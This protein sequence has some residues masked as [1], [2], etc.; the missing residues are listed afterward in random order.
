MILRGLTTLL[1]LI[2]CQAVFAQPTWLK[3]LGTET[4]ENF[5]GFAAD[6]EGNYYVSG[7][8]NTELTID[9]L[10]ITGNIIDLYVAK[11][12][13]NGNI[14]WLK[15]ESSEA[16]YAVYDLITTPDGGYCI[17][18]IY[19]T[20][21]AQFGDITLINNAVSNPY[22]ARYDADGNLLW[23]SG[24][25]GSA[26]YYDIAIDHMGDIVFLG[27]MN[28]SFTFNG[29]EQPRYGDR[30][31]IFGKYASDGTP[32]WIKVLPGTDLEYSSRL[33]IDAE[34]N[35][36]ITGRFFSEFTFETIHFNSYGND[37]AFILKTDAN[38]SP[39]WVN[40]IG[41][42]G[43][44][45]MPEGLGIA[46]N[47]NIYLAI[48]VDD[49][50]YVDAFTINTLG[51]TDMCL[52]EID[53]E[54]GAVN[55]Y[56]TG[57]GYDWDYAYDLVVGSAGVFVC[58]T[59]N[60]DAEFG[61]LQLLGGETSSYLIGYNFEGAAMELTPLT[62]TSTAHAYHLTCDERGG[63]IV[64]GLFNVDIT[65]PGF[66]TI[67]AQGPSDLFFCKVSSALVDIQ[68]ADEQN[69]S[70]EIW[71]N[72]ASQILHV[73]TDVAAAEEVRI[74][75]IQGNRLLMQN[76]QQET[77]VNISGLPAGSYIVQLIMADGSF[78]TEPLIKQ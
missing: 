76:I 67:Y 44:N 71:P 32:L 37:D 15:G 12:D 57:G 6:V 4:G 33:A 42:D 43:N 47:G 25:I 17:S 22:I 14:L 59:V 31:I 58:G 60:G 40:V 46:D 3:R 73:R 34:N 21:D 50:M 8:Y 10:T 55:W 56:Q 53:P 52:M 26:N 24:E 64:A 51:L 9:G 61:G 70:F 1:F 49:G 27:E 7:V 48:T 13:K 72:P 74:F 20:G 45:R 77:T 36:L 68:D 11:F 5:S 41:D 62:S 18:G 63:V 2:T 28:S 30:D 16:Y 66:S 38:G 23:A 69:Q 75:D 19:Y 29:E 39:I 35:I 78:I 65:V 54:N